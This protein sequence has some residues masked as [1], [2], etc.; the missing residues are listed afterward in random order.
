MLLSDVALLHL[1]VAAAIINFINSVAVKRCDFK[2]HPAKLD[3]VS[4]SQ[5]VDLVFRA[6]VP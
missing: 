1:A 6:E 5:T 2:I 4:Y 3:N